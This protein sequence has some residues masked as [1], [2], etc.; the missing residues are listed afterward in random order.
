MG[1]LPH[2]PP[3]WAST[4]SA[5]CSTVTVVRSPLLLAAAHASLFLPADFVMLLS[6]RR[7]RPGQLSLQVIG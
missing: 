6:L 5:V 7:C 4:L 1:S 3:A 2:V